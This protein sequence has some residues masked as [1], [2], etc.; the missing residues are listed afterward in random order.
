M[1]ANRRSGGEQGLLPRPSVYDFLYQDHRRIGAFL[2]QFEDSGLLTQVS[3]QDDSKRSSQTSVETGGDLGIPLVAK[4]HTN[5]KRTW[6][7]EG[8]LSGG[9]VFDPLWV[10]TLTLLDYLETNSLISR[11]ISTSEIG[12]FVLTSGST[13]L[14]DFSLLKA[15]WDMPSVKRLLQ[16]SQPNKTRNGPKNQ[17]NNNRDLL[18]FLQDMLRTLPHTFQLLMDTGSENVWAILGEE[19]ILAQTSEYSLKYGGVLPG[20]WSMLGILDAVPLDGYVWNKDEPF[21]TSMHPTFVDQSPLLD[22]LLTVTQLSQ[23]LLGRRL[24][25]YAM[26]PLMVFRE[27][28]SITPSP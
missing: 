24:D 17:G 5:V 15:S 20:N 19:S 16:N 7:K 11:T 27:I 9:K 28:G 22:V 21:D 4:G 3:S 10:N 25:H 2:S 1:S 23:N 18:A 8:S 26:T 14:N 6:R 12:Q 13:R